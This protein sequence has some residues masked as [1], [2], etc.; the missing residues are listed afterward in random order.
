L[1]KLK[2]KS[3]VIVSVIL[4]SLLTIIYYKQTQD[5]AINN[6]K[7]KI[8]ELLLHYKAVRN[9]VAFVQKDEIYRLQEEGELS[10]EYF[11]PVFLSSTFVARSV[12]DLYNEIQKE[13]GGKPIKIRFAST[14]PRNP[15]N[16]ATIEETTLLKRFNNNEIK[17]FTKIVEKDDEK[18]LYYVL[19][20]KRTTK[21]CMKCHSDPE[22]APPGLIKIYGDKNGFH[23]KVGDIRAV[24]ST[25]Y[26]L[27]KD[28]A[29]ANRVFYQLII[30]TFVI[31]AILLLVVYK[32]IEKLNKIN[33]TLDDKIKIRTEE[34]HSE[35]EYMKTILDNNPSIIIVVNDDKIIN[36]NKQFFKFFD[37]EQNDEIWDIEILD[38]YFTEFD[39]DSF[40]VDKKINGK[41]WYKYLLDKEDS[42]HNV[43]VEVNSTVHSLLVSATL[44]NQKGD[45]VVTLQNVTDQIEKDKLLFEQSKLASMGEMIG[46]IA[47]QWRQPLSII[48]TS[49]TGMLVQKQYDLLSDEQFEKSCNS[50]DENAQYL[51][52]TIDDFRNF[53]KGDREK[54]HFNL[55]EHI[56]I[57]L[58][59][60]DSAVKTYHI[61]VIKD[62]STNIYL[63]G[64]TNELVQCLINIFNN[65]KDVLKEIDE[66]ERLFFVT[67]E[68]QAGNIVIKLTDNAGGIPADVLPRIFEPYFTT[69]HKAQGTGIGL[70]MTYNMIVD[71]MNGHFDATTVS[72]EYEGVN[73]KGAEFK[74]TLPKIII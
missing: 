23:E 39:A 32:F 52:K 1:E 26:P 63:D 58:Q 33:R 40:P 67:V 42:F 24:L 8:N 20:T 5:T 51:S 59:L 62:V 11:N 28:L 6:A 2:F 60:V 14:N 45:I 54:V 48:S 44:L 61:K 69:K 57:F 25:S 34:L 70:H 43:S 36:A 71:G 74:I 12:N 21:K 73:Y 64:Y 7:S 46:N 72:Y 37:Y 53:I 47:H 29:V 13:N 4:F 15:M 9:Y 66:N 38:N 30:I 56:D 10:K 68:K 49:A 19:P 27:D 31:F 35:K 22:I 65:A 18:I 17:D 50:I 55:S 41:E 3:L 16:K